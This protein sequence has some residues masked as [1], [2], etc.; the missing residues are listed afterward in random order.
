MGVRVNGSILAIRTIISHRRDRPPVLPT[1]MPSYQSGRNR[2][3]RRVFRG[4]GGPTDGNLPPRKIIRPRVKYRPG[5]GGG[6]GGDDDDDDDGDGV[7]RHLE[8]ADENDDA[9]DGED[10]GSISARWDV[11]NLLAL[12]ECDRDDDDDDDDGASYDGG[13]SIHPRRGEDDFHLEMYHLRGRIERISHSLRTSRGLSN[14]VTWRTNCL[15]PVRNVAR[16]WRSILTYYGVVASIHR[17][18]VRVRDEYDGGSGGVGMPFPTSTRA[19]GEGGSA[20]VPPRSRDRIDVDGNDQ[21]RATSTMVFGL[22]QT[23]MQIGPLV[24]SNP[25]YFKRCGTEVS[26]LAVAYLFEVLELAGVDAHAMM[27]DE[28]GRTECDV[29]GSVR[30]MNGPWDN[31]YHRDANDSLSPPPRERTEGGRSEEERDANAYCDDDESSGGGRRSGHERDVDLRGEGSMRWCDVPSSEGDSSPSRDSDDDETEC[32]HASIDGTISRG[33]NLPMRDDTM[34]SR[35]NTAR[36]RAI[37]DGIQGS[38]LFT[39]KQSR[40]I[41][42]WLCDAEKAVVRETPPSESARRLQSLRSK[43][44]TLKELKMQR[45]LTK[46]KKGRGGGK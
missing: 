16:E 41:Y 24:G 31:D 5:G 10:G 36:G 6:G 14:P 15:N 2:P 12:D 43:K 38:L 45:K 1:T 22:I 42:K 25:G 30:N 37:I 20:P 17:D 34:A 40:K 32:L 21:L 19:V 13:R 33:S 18:D 46:K 7:G 9:N 39:D 23:S 44:Q 28:D 35:G 4:R 8:D 27:N 29:R 11:G 26:S 3:Q